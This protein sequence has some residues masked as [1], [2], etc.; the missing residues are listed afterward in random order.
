MGR[1]KGGLFGSGGGA[2]SR[3][4]SFSKKRRRALGVGAGK[5]LGGEWLG[6]GDGAWSS[7]E[8][9]GARAGLFGSGG[10]ARSRS[11]SFSKKRRRALGVGA[12]KALVWW[13]GRGDGARSSFEWGGARAGLFGSGGGARS[14][15]ASFSKKREWALG[16]VGAGKA[17]GD[18]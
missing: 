9:G 12:G 18:E 11:A 16:D 5:A 3:S 14:R 10:G 15:S 8:W 7:F 4:A 6:R 1:G 2:R 13:L 17:L